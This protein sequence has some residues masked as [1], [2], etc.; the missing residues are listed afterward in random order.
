[1]GKA[2]GTEEDRQ[3]DSLA[4]PQHQKNRHYQNYQDFQ[5]I[6]IH[7]RSLI[8]QIAMTQDRAEGC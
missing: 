7:Y 1:M 5:Q 8:C 2:E 6:E 4:K 3:P